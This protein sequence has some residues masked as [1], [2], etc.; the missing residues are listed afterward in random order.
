MSNFSPKKG[1]KRRNYLLIDPGA[2]TRVCFSYFISL[3]ANI[4]G[5]CQQN[6]NPANIKHAQIRQ[7]CK[8][9]GNM[10]KPTYDIFDK[11]LE[12]KKIWKKNT[13]IHMLIS[14]NVYLSL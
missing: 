10:S 12:Y 9:N 1:K 4:G 5:C 7:A 13:R 6:H 8:S 3:L 2:M 11:Q 14:H